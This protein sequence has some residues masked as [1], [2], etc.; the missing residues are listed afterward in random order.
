MPVNRYDA[1]GRSAGQESSSTYEGRH[2]TILESL[3]IHPVHADGLVDKGDPVLAGENIVGVAFNSALAATDQIAIDTEGIWFLNVTAVNEGGASAV[4]IGDELYIHKTTAVISKIQNQATHARFGYALSALGSG[5]TG[6][7]AVKVHWDP[8][9]FENDLVYAKTVTFTETAG[10][11]VYTG[12]VNVPAGAFLTDII[13]HAVALWDPVTSAIMKVGDVA[14]D[15]GFFTAVDLKATDLLVGESISFAQAGGKQGAD[16]D[17][18]G[19]AAHV[20]RRYLATA[21]VI[22]G[23]V[24]VVGAVGTASGRTRMTVYY[25]LPVTVIAATKV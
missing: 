22:S 17:V 7:V 25:S 4:V 12:S 5:T 23:I 9:V 1:T 3:L 21:R 20:R 13:V 24:T 19:A 14:D 11:G 6:V 15:D 18:P 10:A 2:L 8:D 16:L